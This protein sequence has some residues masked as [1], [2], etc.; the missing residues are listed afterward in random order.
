MPRHFSRSR[1]SLP[2]APLKFER[3]V[4]K[5]GYRFIAGLDEV[6]RGC[7]AG[8]VFAGV[9]IFSPE[10]RIR[11]V[12][13]SKLL[14]PSKREILS[15]QIREKALAWAIASVEAE[16]IDSI[17]IHHASLLAMKKAVEI[18]SQNSGLK[19]DYLFIDGKFTLSLETHQRALVNGD[20]LSHTIAAA[21]ILAKVSR[22]ALMRKLHLQ[23]PHYGFDEHKGY[24][25]LKHRE[26][27]KR[28]GL[29]PLHRRTFCKN[30]TSDF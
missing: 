30:F 13:D 12:T 27:I 8:P 4:W 5:K 17:N 25:T 16:E 20:R 10:T 9:V 7:L 1:T 3:Q 21:S 24:A 2:S 22:D 18:I 29:T 11:G 6:G 23:Y 28:H 14:S 26:A 19:P 15:Q